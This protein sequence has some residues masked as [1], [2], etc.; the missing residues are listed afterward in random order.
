MHSNIVI[1]TA[2]TA[3]ISAISGLTTTTSSAASSSSSNEETT[4]HEAS[5]SADNSSSIRYHSR[6][7]TTNRSTTNQ[8]SATSKTSTSSQ[9]GLGLLVG[10][11][12]TSSNSTSLIARSSACSAL[13]HAFQRALQNS[14]EWMVLQ[15]PSGTGKSAVVKQ[16][17]EELLAADQDF[18]WASGKF[19]QMTSNS[20]ESSNQQQQ[21]TQQQQIRPFSGITDAISDLCFQILEQEQEHQKFRKQ[22]LEA[23]PIQDDLQALLQ[24]IPA[25]QRIVYSNSSEK[26]DANDTPLFAT[27]SNASTPNYTPHS[28][29]RLVKSVGNVL[30]CAAHAHFPLIL[31]LDDLQWADPDSQR[32][33]QALARNV[34]LQY[35]LC[36]GT[37]R[38]DETTENA[39]SDVLFRD[40][41]LPVST[42]TLGPLTDDE[43]HTLVSQLLCCESNSNKCRDL[44]TLISRQTGG[45]PLFVRQFLE[46]LWRQRII[47]SSARTSTDN[48]QF[49]W[50][51][52]AEIEQRISSNTSTDILHVYTQRMQHDVGLTERMILVTA[53]IL[54]FSFP[55]EIVQELVST[56]QE[57][58]KEVLLVCDKEA[59]DEKDDKEG[60][61]QNG[62][63]KEDKEAKENEKDNQKDDKDKE[64]ATI[65]TLAFAKALKRITTMGLVVM[66]NSSSS[67][68]QW[69]QFTHDR[70]QQSAHALLTL[71]ANSNAANDIKRK[72]G[73]ILYDIVC[74]RRAQQEGEEVANGRLLFLATNLLIQYSSSDSSNKNQ[75]IARL[76]LQ[77]AQKASSQSAFRSA[78]SYADAGIQKLGGSTACWDAPH[79]ELGLE[80]CTTAA[81]MHSATGNTEVCVSRVAMIKRKAAHSI[82]DQFRAIRVLIECYNIHEEWS[83]TV[84][85]CRRALLQI[86][87]TAIANIKKTKGS[88][89]AKWCI[90]VPKRVSKFQVIRQYLRIKRFINGRTPEQLKQDLPTVFDPI[91]NEMCRIVSAFINASFYASEE[92]LTMS[93]AMNALLEFTFIGGIGGYAGLGLIAYAVTLT[94]LGDYETANQFGRAAMTWA[95]DYGGYEGAF[96]TERA[97]GIQYNLIN[98]LQYPMHENFEGCTKAFE[99]C[100]VIGDVQ[101]ACYNLRTRIALG[102]YAE[103][104][105]KDYELY[106]CWVSSLVSWCCFTFCGI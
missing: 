88:T 20:T 16:V 6:S 23:I 18:T 76:C 54:G 41:L 60:S 71:N 56:L 30:R 19:E 95:H 106:V 62:N 21:E 78:A 5:S 96:T 46:L 49:T 100:M 68:S 63:E 92:R 35:C 105:L 37:M 90:T 87:A 48:H 86:K 42:I 75:D 101:Y 83:S 14:A 81:E 27:T 69:Y 8:S 70:V 58:L 15:G 44:S 4:S 32:L 103:T 10:N 85:E 99:A 25:L 57:E 80:L 39:I 50:P 82:Q 102:L 22:L 59:S 40:A 1:S 11:N 12:T 72:M 43:V 65:S 34:Q 79:Y 9:S 97:M 84:R 66:S 2:T 55:I 89:D 31:F 36:I 52:V 3:P 64:A 33:L 53:S 47:T 67:K 51:P 38:T 74:Q 98:H 94:R 29:N 91:P 73:T 13:H 77:A 104:D 61:C 26:E 28:F 7:T 93:Y 17:Q 24:L 45:N